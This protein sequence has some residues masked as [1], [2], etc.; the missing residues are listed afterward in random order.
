MS[1]YSSPAQ[2]LAAEG[3][4]VFFPNYRASTGRGV[5]FSKM[6]QH[7]LAE[8]EFNDLVDAKNHLVEMGLVDTER[9]GITGGSYGGYATMWASTALSEH[10]AA[11][12]AFVGISSQLSMFGTSDIPNEHHLVHHRAW[13]WD[14]WQWLLERS[15]IYYADKGRTPLLILHGKEDPRVH[16]GQSLEMYRYLKLRTDTPVRLVWYPGEGHGN[17]STAAQLDY[18]MRLLR[19]LTH[20]LQGPGGEAPAYDL[21]HAARLEAAQKDAEE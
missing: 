16:P 19:W 3:F 10:F 15:P 17:R 14:D 1:R 13:P 9:V 5:E 4:A 20:F 2:T 6:D 7:D 8:E 18:G 11:G 12:V 21:G